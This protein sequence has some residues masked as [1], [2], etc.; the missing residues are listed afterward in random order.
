MS[1]TFAT[2]RMDPELGTIVWPNGADLDAAVLRAVI[3]GQLQ[4]GFAG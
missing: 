4:R 2:V 1:G 3:E